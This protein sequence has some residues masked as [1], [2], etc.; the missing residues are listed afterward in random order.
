M[1]TLTVERLRK[2][3]QTFDWYCTTA[4]EQRVIQ[5]GCGGK[6]NWTNGY[7]CIISIWPVQHSTS[8]DMDIIMRFIDSRVKETNN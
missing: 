3:V 5:V 7:S 4:K 2:C 8:Q 1:H 6:N